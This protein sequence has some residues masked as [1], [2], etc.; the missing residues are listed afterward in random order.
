[1]ICY[2]GAAYCLFTQAGG[3]AEEV[4]MMQCSDPHIS[5]QQTVP[6]GVVDAYSSNNA[7]N[8]LYY[9]LQMK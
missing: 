1:V 5:S 6:A 3:F 7:N 9:L 2:T 4:L 8:F